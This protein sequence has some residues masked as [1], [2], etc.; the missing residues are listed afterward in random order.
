MIVLTPGQ[1]DHLRSEMH[2]AHGTTLT[3]IAACGYSG[4]GSEKKRLARRK[5]RARNDRIFDLV[6]TN[7]YASAD[8]ACSS[9]IAIVLPFVSRLFFKWAVKKIVI[10]LWNR[11]RPTQAGRQ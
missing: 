7:D 4:G 8:E 3:D 2:F 11:T 5:E 10:W 1:L 6:T 9:I